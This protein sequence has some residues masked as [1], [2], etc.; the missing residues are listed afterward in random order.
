M[1]FAAA[2]GVRGPLRAEAWLR[3]AAPAITAR[4]CQPGYVCGLMVCDAHEFQ[5]ASWGQVL[6]VDP[7]P[8]G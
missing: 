7:H 6:L 1:L 5:D 4:L 2:R 8:E 3:E